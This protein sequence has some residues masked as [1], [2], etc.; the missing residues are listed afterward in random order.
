MKSFN[1]DRL[2]A[3]RQI[4]QYHPS[5]ANCRARFIPFGQYH[6]S[7]SAVIRLCG[8][9]VVRVIRSRIEMIPAIIEDGRG[10]LN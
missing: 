8:A 5:L 2:S 10:L 9:A 7:N 6:I 4:D 1:D 3:S